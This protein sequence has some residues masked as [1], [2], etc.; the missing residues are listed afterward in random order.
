[1]ALTDS[2]MKKKTHIWLRNVDG[3]QPNIDTTKAVLH[4]KE[5]HIRAEQFLYQ[6]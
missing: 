2:W 3:A 4:S 5:L 1:M 6:P